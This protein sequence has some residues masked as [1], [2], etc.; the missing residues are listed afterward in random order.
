VASRITVDSRTAPSS[1]T[2]PSAEADLIGNRRHA[3][4][5]PSLLATIIENKN[6]FK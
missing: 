4:H 6:D 3:C 2:N 5:E 1:R